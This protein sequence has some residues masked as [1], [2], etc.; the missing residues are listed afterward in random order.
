MQTWQNGERAEV[1]RD[2]INKNF[3]ALERYLPNSILSLSTE[4]RLLLSSEYLRQGLIVFDTDIQGW[5]KYNGE[6]WEDYVFPYTGYSQTISASDWGL[7]NTIII[8]FSDHLTPNPNVNMYI[9]YNGKYE[10]VE[11]GYSVDDNFTITLSSDLAFDGKVV[12]K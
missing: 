10:P 5:L 1:V 9:L 8:P 7:T 6:T 11:G 4:R 2:I 3:N 12:I